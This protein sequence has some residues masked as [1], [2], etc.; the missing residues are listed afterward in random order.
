MEESSET[1][2]DYMVDVKR[3]YLVP[4]KKD[5]KKAILTDTSGKTSK[6]LDKTVQKTDLAIQ[7]EGSLLPAVEVT[8]SEVLV[9][10]AAT[11]DGE[12]PDGYKS[13]GYKIDD[14]DR[15]QN[16]G[17]KNKKDYTGGTKCYCTLQSL[18][19]QI[20]CTAPLGVSITIDLLLED[21]L[22]K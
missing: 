4:I 22:T 3:E 6:C 14:R 8:D 20:L 9:V 21:K 7:E 17:W 10:N 19:C 15:Q 12:T 5:N 2:P 13:N 18:Q 1:C 11:G 16:N